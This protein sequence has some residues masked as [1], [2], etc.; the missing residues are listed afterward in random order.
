MKKFIDT[1]YGHRYACGEIAMALQTRNITDEHLDY[2]AKLALKRYFSYKNV[3]KN[4]N[5]MITPTKVT[6]HEFALKNYLANNH[7]YSWAWEVKNRIVKLDKTA[8]PFFN[9][10]LLSDLDHMFKYDTHWNPLGAYKYFKSFLE[11]IEILNLV[12]DSIFTKD[13]NNILYGNCLHIGERLGEKYIDVN[14]VDYFNVFKTPA[15]PTPDLNIEVNRSHSHI[16]NE[17]VL[18][19]HSSSYQFCRSFISGLFKETIEIFCPYVPAEIIRLGSFDRIIIQSAERNIAVAYDGALLSENVL[20]SINNEKTKAICS[21]IFNTVATAD[22]SDSV[23]DFLLQLAKH[24]SH[25]E[26][27]I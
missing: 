27:R 9:P 12:S 23:R 11:E 5:W 1:F 3:V 10:F 7:A 16:I 21:Y 8:T 17:R 18:I 15:F 25:D 6:A 22:L 2:V 4:V 19:I 24:W 26:I 20:S 14:S 13:N